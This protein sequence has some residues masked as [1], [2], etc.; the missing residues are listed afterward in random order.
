M[1]NEIKNNELEKKIE[2]GIGI[3][4]IIGGFI[5]RLIIASTS[6]DTMYQWA[7]KRREYRIR[8]VV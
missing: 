4:G 1:S 2:F 6:S 8:T 5:W 3:I 7:F